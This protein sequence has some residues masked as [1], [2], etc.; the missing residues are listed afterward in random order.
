MRYNTPI[1]FETRKKGAYN[2]T[3]GNYDPETCEAVK[4]YAAITETGT[5]ALKLIYG[6]IKQGALTIRLQR[7]YKAA[8]DRVRIGECKSAKYYHV[9]R[10]RLAKRVFIVSEVQ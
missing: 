7:P 3:T 4:R 2:S 6:D 9:D 5:E 8:F 1:Y 10:A